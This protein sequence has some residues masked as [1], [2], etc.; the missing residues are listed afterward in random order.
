MDFYRAVEIYLDSPTPLNFYDDVILRDDGEGPYIE[1]WNISYKS[2]PTPELL[3]TIMEDYELDEAK[4][5]KL[6]ELEHCFNSEMCSSF[7]S[8]VSGE[9][10]RYSFNEEAQKYFLIAIDAIDLIDD[11]ELVVEWRTVDDNGLVYLTKAQV[12]QLYLESSY[13]VMSRLGMYRYN[14]QQIEALTTVEDVNN[15]VFQ[16]L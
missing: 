15:Y 8:D 1:Q 12:K 7:E 6:I 5:L 10:H 4:R 9:T 3:E 13:F 16:R 2:C 11:P 14:Q